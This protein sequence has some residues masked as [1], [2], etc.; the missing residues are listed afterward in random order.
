MNPSRF[1]K[2]VFIVSRSFE[3][4]LVLSREF[5]QYGFQIYE[6]EKTQQIVPF[7]KV[8]KPDVCI[9]H[10]DR[11][12]ENIV[13]HISHVLEETQ[14]KCFVIYLLDLKYKEQEFQTR[15]ELIRIGA[16]QISYLEN[17]KIKE[18]NL[19]LKEIDDYFELEIENMDYILYIRNNEEFN[20]YYIQL[21]KQKFKVDEFSYQ[22]IQELL[23]SKN[24]F[25]LKEMYFMIILNMYYSDFLGVELASMIRQFPLLKHIP[26]IFISKEK[27]IGKL[28][29]T[30]QK[31]GDE[32]L[33]HP[34][35][36]QIF[37]TFINSHYKKYKL[38]K[39]SLEKDRMTNLYN[40]HSFLEKLEAKIRIFQ[41]ASQNFACCMVDIDNFKSINDT[42]GHLAGDQ[43]IINL[44]R[45]LKYNLRNYDFICRYGGEEFA[46]I[47]NVNDKDSAIKIMDRIRKNFSLLN[48]HF[49]ENSFSCTIS[50]GIAM[51]FDFLEMKTLLQAA[52][53]GLYIA[54]K[55]GKNKVIL[56]EKL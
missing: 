48:H 47:L 54:K 15:L 38:L 4:R 16:N 24:I 29:H 6:F 11:T 7:V 5:S 13:F 50:I 19:I 10:Y 37:F 12:E 39:N 17:N 3:Q 53:S 44:A 32:Y 35:D 52:D 41:K 8:Q 34:I 33:V 26:I 51:F 2:N 42:Y 25:I 45:F 43:V 9:I 40:H 27:E 1:R 36:S 21:L 49:G 20:N 22:E 28:L 23:N 55:Q 56:V 31:G 14:H 46:V 30:I 18:L